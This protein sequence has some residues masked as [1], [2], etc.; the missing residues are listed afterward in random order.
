MGGKN[1]KHMTKDKPGKPT[2]NPGKTKLVFEQILDDRG[3]LPEAKTKKERNQAKDLINK[4]DHRPISEI[5]REKQKTIWKIG[6]DDDGM[7]IDKQ[8]HMGGRNKDK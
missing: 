1:Q 5:Y 8:G 4:I 7:R 3:E 2:G 6:T